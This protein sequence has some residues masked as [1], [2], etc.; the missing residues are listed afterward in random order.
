MVLLEMKK[1][2][3]LVFSQTVDET[4]AIKANRYIGEKLLLL[5]TITSH[6]Y[7]KLQCPF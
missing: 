2:G 1:K 6:A 3:D 7:L 4:F 5:V